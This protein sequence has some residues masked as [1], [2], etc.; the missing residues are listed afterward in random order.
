MIVG[1]ALIVLGIHGFTRDDASEDP[2]KTYGAATGAIA[3]GLVCIDLGL[4][5]VGVIESVRPDSWWKPNDLN[6][7]GDAPTLPGT[8]TQG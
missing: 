4:E 1:V 2:L 6:P 8:T 7:G 5:R 3:L